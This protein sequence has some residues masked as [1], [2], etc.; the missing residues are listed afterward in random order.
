MKYSA[1][2]GRYAKALLDVGIDRGLEEEYAELLRVCVEIYDSMKDFFDDPTL[3][4]EKKL[5]VMVNVLEKT[6][7]ELDEP[8]KN[9]LR[10][11]FERKRQK[12][13]P[14]IL[15]FYTDLKIEAR[16]KIPVNVY[17]PYQLDEGEM[18]LLRKFV[19]KHALKEPEFRIEVVEDLLAGVRLEFEGLTYDVSVTGRLKRL[20]RDVFGKG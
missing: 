17:S 8:F 6:G 14:L 16:G 1:V 9:F 11:V 12:H 5:S 4:S 20:Y 18:E 15:E 7:F 2:A 3:S 10:I 13:L 19:K